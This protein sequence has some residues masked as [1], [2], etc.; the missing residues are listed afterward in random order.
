MLLSVGIGG[1]MLSRD[2]WL[3]PA[4]VAVTVTGV[5]VVTIPAVIENVVELDPCGIVTLGGTFR[6]G[7]E[8]AREINA[9]PLLAA[10]VR[11]T[12]QT[13]D[14][15]EASDIGLQ[16]SPFNAGGVMPIVDPTVEVA[17]DIPTASAAD[18]C[19]SWTSEELDVVELETVKPTVATTPFE[20]GVVLKPYK[21]HFFVPGVLVQETDLFALIPDDPSATLTD[22]KSLVE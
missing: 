3:T 12:L 9:P 11:A 19:E 15:C 10:A 13:A 7:A 14:A 2:V 20:S 1:L 5:N 18:P 16:N 8:D 6:A 21:T 22:E 17:N 4:K